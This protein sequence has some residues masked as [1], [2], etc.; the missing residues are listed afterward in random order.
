MKTKSMFKSELANAA[1]VSLHTFS[2]WCL[3]QEPVLLPMGYRRSQHLLTPAQVHHLCTFYC[4][5]LDDE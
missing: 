1:G 5:H 3:E 4:I 2:K